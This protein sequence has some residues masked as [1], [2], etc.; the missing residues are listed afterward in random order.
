[1]GIRRRLVAAVAAAAADR[2]AK[3]RIRAAHNIILRDVVVEQ[4]E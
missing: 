1:M 2:Y 4:D 3:S